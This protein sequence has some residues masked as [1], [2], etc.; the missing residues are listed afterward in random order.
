[1]T[2]IFS[3]MFAAN[4]LMIIASVLAFLCA[5]AGVALYILYPQSRV[6]RHRFWDRPYRFTGYIFSKLPK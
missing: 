3:I 5:G 4:L 6:W 1:M 2:S